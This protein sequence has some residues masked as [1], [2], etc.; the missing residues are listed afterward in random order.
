M[1]V[2][3]AISR[4]GAELSRKNIRKYKPTNMYQTF[5]YVPPHLANVFNFAPSAFT[6]TV[7]IGSLMRLR[8]D[9]VARLTSAM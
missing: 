5:Q 7:Y 9:N 4:A 6:V 1:G 8:A 3:M 2:V